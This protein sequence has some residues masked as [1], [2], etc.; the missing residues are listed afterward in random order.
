MSKKETPV[1][2]LKSIEEWQ[3]KARP[4]RDKRI[5]F[6]CHFE[7]LAE[8]FEQL[9]GDSNSSRHLFEIHNSLV[10]LSDM[11]KRDVTIIGVRDRKAMLDALGDQIVTAVGVG[12][13]LEM[14]VPAAV[15]EIDRSNYSKM[16]DGDFIRNDQGKIMKGETYSP[17][18]L[19][20]MF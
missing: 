14:N 6:A 15:A 18:N 3:R 9:S 20:G 13:N 4:E 5:A 17:P 1:D 8:M 16:V 7:E 19:E 11:L 10:K 2:T 12:H